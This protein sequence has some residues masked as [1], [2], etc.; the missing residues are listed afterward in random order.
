MGKAGRKR[1]AG[2][3]TPSGQLSRATF[4]HGTERV[5]AMQAL[6]GQDG[7]DAI[8]RA[9]RSGL[10]GEGSEAKSLLDTARRL[11]NVYW[12]AYEVGPIGCTLGDQSG[13]GTGQIDHDKVKR[14]ETW[15]NDSRICVRKMGDKVSRAFDQLVIDPMPDKGPPWLDRLCAAK[16]QGE[17]L[18]VADKATL[19][20]ALDGLETLA[21]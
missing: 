9:Y 7:A 15:L 2:K 4:D 1:K 18:P 13:G 16:R 17:P 20:A 12:R 6:Y 11:S 14:Q 3:R 10:L 5:Q 8:G 19:R 21:D